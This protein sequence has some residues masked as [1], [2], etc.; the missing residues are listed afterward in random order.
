MLTTTTF[1][2]NLNASIPHSEEKNQDHARRHDRNAQFTVPEPQQ[3]ACGDATER[4]Y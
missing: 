4:S 1:R 2:G 3:E